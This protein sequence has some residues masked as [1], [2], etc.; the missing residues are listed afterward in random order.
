M[1]RPPI[2][3]RDLTAL[4]RLRRDLL[5]DGAT[6]NQIDCLVRTGRLHRVRY[7]AYVPTDVWES[8]SAEDRHRLRARAGKMHDNFG[9]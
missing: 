4:V 8:C 6:D 9:R 2:S 7:G 1:S 5:A 3:P